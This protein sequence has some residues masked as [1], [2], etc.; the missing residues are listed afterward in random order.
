MA[1]LIPEERL[2]FAK[3]EKVNN[4]VSVFEPGFTFLLIASWLNCVLAFTFIFFGFFCAVT[5][6]MEF[7][8]Y[9]IIGGK[10]LWKKIT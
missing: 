9:L 1:F 8:K 7:T 2:N 3:S 4:H 5:A 6:Y 10:L